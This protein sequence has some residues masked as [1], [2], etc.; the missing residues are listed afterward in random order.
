MDNLLMNAVEEI[1]GG[2]NDVAPPHESELPDSQ[3]LNTINLGKP[4]Q[5][6]VAVRKRLAELRDADLVDL[7]AKLEE[8]RKAVEAEK[9]V[10]AEA[11]Y[12][13][14]AELEKGTSREDLASKHAAAEIAE[15]ILRIKQDEIDDVN[16]EIGRVTK[17][18]ASKS[19]RVM[20]SIQQLE[21]AHRRYVQAY[22]GGGS[23]E[24]KLNPERQERAFFAI[25]NTR[26][27]LLA[28]LDDDEL[29]EAAM[30]EA[31]TLHIPSDYESVLWSLMTP[32]G[33]NRFKNYDPTTNDKEAN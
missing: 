21:I 15:G 6:L 4:G 27:L 17:A 3:Q 28:T 2:G 22:A 19:T 20:N 23:Q 16:E 12:D 14:K 29:A 33:R 24:I 30:A 8:L 25:V 13:L 5:A 10:I 18:W 7:K 32:K 31:T 1:F 9:V 11:D 26:E